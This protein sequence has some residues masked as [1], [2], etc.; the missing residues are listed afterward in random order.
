MD[1]SILEREAVANEGAPR[2]LLVAG[3]SGGI[4]SAF[5]RQLAERFPSATLVRLARDLSSL[6]QL[7]TT[8]VDI[9]FDI[10]EEDRISEAI[11]Q[12][13]D[14]LSI[15]W[16]FVATGWLHNDG[17]G[18]EKIY[19]SLDAENLMHA[20]RINAIGPALLLKHLIP[21][22]NASHECKL[23]I[24]SARVGS[25][26]DNRLGGWHSYRASKAA[27]NM[28]IK[29]FAIEL[30]RKK[31]RHIIVGL[32]PGTTD[33]ALSAPFQRNV[34]EGQLQTPDYTAEQLLKVMRELRPED[35]GGLFDF[36]GIPF[37]P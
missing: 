10:G 17:N 28:L 37:A 20:Y 11:A 9:E 16:V 15:D 7:A 34:P 26:S 2:C 5:C 18:P 8:T 21:K 33:T 29:N 27:L 1:D 25:I 14:E 6:Q 30:A 32:Q 12:I 19:T 22:L 36:L 3:A 4:G 13:P 24:V 31:P 35:S 23:G